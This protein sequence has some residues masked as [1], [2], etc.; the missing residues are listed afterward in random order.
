[1]IDLNTTWFIL[2]GVLFTGYAILDGFDFGVGILHLFAKNNNERRINMNAIGPVWD[3]NEVWLLTGGGALFAAFPIVYAT[4]FS[5]FYLAL[6]LI[7]AALIFRAVSLEF[8]SK[9]DSPGWQRFWDWSFGLGSLLPAVLFGVAAGNILRGIP[10]DENGVFVGSFLG[11]LN[12]YSILIGVLSLVMFALHGALY[13]TLKTDG[14]LRDKMTKWASGSW[15]GIII[16]YLL[17]TIYTFFEAGF[18]FDGIL[19]APLFWILFILLLAVIIFI[20]IGLK[21]GRYFRSFL[22]S[23]VTIICMIGLAAVSLFPRLVPSNIDLRYSL[24]IYNASSTPRTLTVMLIMALIGMPIVIG[25]TIYI[26]R[27]FKGK[28]VITD[29]SY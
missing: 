6:M 5:G 11:L 26:Y 15:I 22:A 23:S 13:M 4:V 18:L 25:C 7:L 8:R 14:E 12:P 1:M 28:T 16:V 27:V 2:I 10:L 17:A 19:S 3:A 9:I 20:P 29:E 21:S 24:N